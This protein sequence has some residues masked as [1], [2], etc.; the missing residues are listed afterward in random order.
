M[1][2]YVTSLQGRDYTALL[3]ENNFDV[4]GGF[5]TRNGIA[6]YVKMG[7]L[8][9]LQRLIS[10]VGHSVIVTSRT[11]TDQRISIAAEFPKKKRIA[12]YFITVY[13]GYLED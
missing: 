8:R 5:E 11:E 7:T 13:N 10:V 4:R 1:M 12:S 2:V 3:K 6:P 9:D